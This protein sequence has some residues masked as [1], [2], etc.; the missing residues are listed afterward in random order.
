MINFFPINRLAFNKNNIT[1]GYLCCQMLELWQ[2]ALRAQFLQ[3][4]VRLIVEHNISF[5]SVKS[6]VLA[7]VLVEAV[8]RYLPDQ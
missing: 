3:Q 4:E 1:L 2:A 8:K 5:A 6:A 7:H